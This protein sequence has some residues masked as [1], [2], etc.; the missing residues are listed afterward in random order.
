M[1][2]SIRQYKTSQPKEFTKRVNESWVP[3]ISKVPDFIAYYAIEKGEGGFQS[4]FLRIKQGRKNLI[5]WP[6][7]G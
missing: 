4:A 5:R 1:Y 6:R 2:L 3:V 7:N